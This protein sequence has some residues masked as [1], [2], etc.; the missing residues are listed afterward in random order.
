MLVC[1]AAGFDVVII[2]TMGVGQSE[3][4]VASMV[5]FFLVLM[6]AGAG[7]ELQG[8]KKGVLELADAVA[9]NKA[10]GDNL[11]NAKK[12]RKAYEN[13]LNLLH[14]S[15][16]SWKPPVL[17][18]S[19]IELSGIKAI[20]NTVSEHRRTLSASGELKERRRNQALD[21]MWSIV[22]EGLK[23]RFYRHPDIK[24]LL[25]KVTREVETGVT[26]PTDAAYALLSLLDDKNT[27]FA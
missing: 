11:K 4:K 18:C 25:D 3:T 24:N 19:A 21:W 12:A 2:E 15:S 22:E 10:D 6:L 7:D 8:I 23:E 16:Q 5:D 14:P 17:I 20:W 26:A 9:V 1:E 13:A 27:A